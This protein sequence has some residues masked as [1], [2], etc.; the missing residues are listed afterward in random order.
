M[1]RRGLGIKKHIEQLSFP[2]RQE[3]E[4][5]GY[6]ATCRAALVRG[7]LKQRSHQR[8]YVYESIVIDILPHWGTVTGRWPSHM[9][10]DEIG[11][12]GQWASMRWRIAARGSLGRAYNPILPVMEQVV[13][14]VISAG[15]QMGEYHIRVQ[16]ALEQA[17]K[18]ARDRIAATEEGWEYIT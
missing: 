15:T 11:M 7:W 10:V 16:R 13:L 6:P 14:P 1:S 3:L 9:I 8:A 2:V 18:R 4:L 12:R 17:Y 5:N